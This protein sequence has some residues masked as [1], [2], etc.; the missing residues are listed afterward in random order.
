MNPF[1]YTVMQYLDN[2]ESVSREKLRADMA[3]AYLVAKIGNNYSD[4][5]A[6]NALCCIVARDIKQVNHWL[7]EFFDNSNETK[8]DY[9]DEINKGKAMGNET[10]LGKAINWDMVP[11][12]INHLN[13]CI[14]GDCT[15]HLGK[16]MTL[17]ARPRKFED[18]AGYPVVIDNCKLVVYYNAGNYTFCNADNVYE[19]HEFS[20]I[21]GKLP[22]S[23]WSDESKKWVDKQEQKFTD[24]KQGEI[25]YIGQTERNNMHYKR[26][27]YDYS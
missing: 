22:G 14:A 5:E 1:M 7:E 21:G 19:E 25:K 11:E 27:F 23:L 12:Q 17:I 13:I 24:Y 10:D 16:E 26:F 3:A 4:H 15:A 9:I 18:G 8:Q 2:P 6:H 20:F